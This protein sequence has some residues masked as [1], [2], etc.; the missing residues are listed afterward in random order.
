MTAGSRRRSQNFSGNSS[1]RGSSGPDT[2]SSPSPNARFTAATHPRWGRQSASVRATCAAP[3]AMACRTPVSAAAPVPFSGSWTI[4]TSKGGSPAA[5][6]LTT[7][8]VPSVLPLSTTTS[9]NAVSVCSASRRSVAPI[10][11]SSS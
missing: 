4:R 6:S 11:R 10:D 3:E 1:V 2:I 8:A 7:V 5:N 9:V